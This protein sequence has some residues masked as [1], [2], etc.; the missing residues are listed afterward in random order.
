MVLELKLRQA[1]NVLPLDGQCRVSDGAIG[2]V[3]RCGIVA[4]G[5]VRDGGKVLEAAGL[6]LG[7]VQLRRLR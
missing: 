1:D 2:R 3:Q 7:P 4:G 5:E 6:D